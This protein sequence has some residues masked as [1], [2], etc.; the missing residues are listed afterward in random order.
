MNKHYHQRYLK[1]I[2]SR[3]DRNYHGV[4]ESH[5]ILPKSLGGDNSTE[6]LIDLSPREHFLAHWM[7]WKAYSNKQ[8]TLAFWSMRMNRSNHRSFK[9]NSKVYQIL[10]ED[11]SK[12]QSERMQT[13]NPMKNEAVRQRVSVSR[14]KLGWTPSEE[15]RKQI[16]DALL[17]RPKTKEHAE[18]ISKGSKGKP[19]SESHKQSMSENHADITGDKNPM[20]GR[21]AA[22]ENNLKWYTNGVDN[23]FLPESTQPEGWVRGRTVSKKCVSPTLHQ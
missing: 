4:V 22:K 19:K 10:K 17:G 9:V 12:V 15:H 11:H 18:N 14:K 23:K 7:L 2:E 16:S 21:S 20:F 3:R 1:F 6:N 13:N 8:M 5:H